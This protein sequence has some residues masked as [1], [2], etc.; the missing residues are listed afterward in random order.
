MNPPPLAFTYDDANR[1][2]TEWGAN[3]GP[4]ALAAALGL[5]LEIIRTAIPH[6]GERGYTSP[7]M[8]RAALETLG[9]TVLHDLRERETDVSMF[10]THGLVRLQWEGP[11]TAP[12]SNPLWTYGH[13][14]WIASRLWEDALWVFDINS[15]WVLGSRWVA[16]IVPTLIAEHPRATG[17]WW[18]T[19]RWT[20]G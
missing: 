13:T 19:H 1:A 3:C 5:H 10:P 15:G 7:T 20:L 4:G 8:M 11:W 12:G 9:A 17:D 14:H 2:A 18:A 16:R 6:F